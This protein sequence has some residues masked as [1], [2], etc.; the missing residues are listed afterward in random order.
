MCENKLLLNEAACNSKQK[1]NHDKCRYESKELDD[2]GSCERCWSCKK[3][4]IG[5]LVLA[6]E[7]KIITTLTKISLDNEKVTCEKYN[8]LV[9]NILLINICLLLIVI[10]SFSC[11]Y[12]YARDWIRNEPVISHIIIKLII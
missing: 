7:D 4:L 2:W 1:W 12:Y 3:C 11:Y 5:K 9:H 6:C 8:F 10:I